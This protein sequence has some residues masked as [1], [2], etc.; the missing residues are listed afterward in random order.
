[1]E[2]LRNFVFQTI[3]SHP[4]LEDQILDLYQL[5]KDEIESGGSMS[6]EIEICKIAIND[7]LKK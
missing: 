7:L 3:N 2:Q 4:E 5:C 6:Y 1:M